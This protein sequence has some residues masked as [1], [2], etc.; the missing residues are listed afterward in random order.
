MTQ[1]FNIDNLATYVVDTSNKLLDRITDLY[2]K[3]ITFEE[4]VT[5]SG[6]LTVNGTTVTIN[7]D[8]YTTE[9]LQIA[10]DSENTLPL[11]KIDDN[12]TSSTRNIIEVYK[13]NIEVFSIDNSGKLNIQGTDPTI[14]IFD[15]RE[16]GN[17]ILSL[18]E[19]NDNYG[20]DFA[21]IG[22]DDNKLYIKCYNNSPLARTD[23]TFVRSNGYVGIG[24]T[25]PTE[26]LEV[27]GNLKVSGNLKVM[28]ITGENLLLQ[29]SDFSKGNIGLNFRMIERNASVSKTSIFAV[30]TTWSRSDLHFCLDNSVGDH[31]QS[32]A[33]PNVNTRMVIQSGGNVGIGT[34]TP[35]E[36]LEV[37]GNLK[38]SGNLT[39]TG[40]IGLLDINKTHAV[41]VSDAGDAQSFNGGSAC[42][43]YKYR[44]FPR[45]LMTNNTT[46]MGSIIVNVKASNIIHPYHAPWD[47]FRG[48]VNTYMWSS[49]GGYT[50]GVAQNTYLVGYAGEWLMIDLGEKIVLKKI[51]IHSAPYGFNGMPKKFRIY[52]TNNNQSF[53]NGTI[54]DINWN[55]LFEG[56]FSKKPTNAYYGENFDVVNNNAYRHYVFIYHELFPGAAFTHIGYTQLFGYNDGMKDFNNDILR[57][58]TVNSTNS[59]L[60]Y[61][62][63]DETCK[64]SVRASDGKAFF[65]GDVVTD[66]N[67]TV[68]GIVKNN[69]FVDGKISVAYSPMD[70]TKTGIGLYGNSTNWGTYVVTGYNDALS[71]GGNIACRGYGFD[72]HAVRF[73]TENNAG[74]GIIYETI[75]PTTKAE[76]CKFSVRASD[77]LGY[78]A[79][80]IYANGSGTPLSFTGNHICKSQTLNLYDNKYIGYIVSSAKKYKSI[81]SKYDPHNIKQNI[82][83]ENNDCLPVV[84]LASKPND[85]NV[86]GVI[87]KIESENNTERLQENG[88]LTSIFKKE[89]YDTSLIISGCG[90]GFLWVSDYNGQIEAGDLISSSPIPGIGM[91][92][93]DDLLRSY[94][95]A[96]ITMD[97]DFNPA[98]IPVRVIQSSNCDIEY[99]MTSNIVNTSN[100][101]IEY[102]IIPNMSFASNIEVENTMT[103]NITVE[104]T[105]VLETTCSSNVTIYPRNENGEF[106]YEN[107]LDEDGN[108]IY[109]Y[110]Y[111]MK[112][113]RLDGTITN[114]NE[115][116]NGSNVY[117]M[118][119]VGGCYKCS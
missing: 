65:A 83:K 82:D 88:S 47:S 56:G 42:E 60:V 89:S 112:Y 5:V 115:Y 48:N 117:R 45:Q 107:Q 7:T 67:L 81:N 74:Y 52:G 71:M 73:R 111:E 90:E 108:I 43:G 85:K 34:T 22:N 104:Y 101:E 61:E 29:T 102:T 59:G 75:N 20:Y 110:E 118:A 31:A 86:F 13:E 33:E 53:V 57:L 63:S 3:D 23:M 8:A 32:S 55:L 98:L 113:V 58:R 97:C 36:K 100:Y 12:S 109:D 17:A 35:T 50:D 87:S 78:F 6:D 68:N 9:I 19:K 62:T 94:T 106:I 21:Y 114:E 39:T 105:T 1:I 91:K 30:H 77:G 51:R 4:N 80:N 66:G 24:T 46:I 37:S 16:N 25:Y 38:V 26:R 76:E 18:K 69:L 14:K 70:G 93:D 28:D 64:F 79:G 99:M 40:G 92:Q 119:L 103:S 15:T 41:Y 49:N 44:L 27:N 96:K 84:E 116:M 54:D 11:L 2:T 95:V 72:H 10:N